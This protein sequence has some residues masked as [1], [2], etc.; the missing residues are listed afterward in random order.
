MEF[1]FKPIGVLHTPNIEKEKSPIQS[2]RS[3]LAGT[4]EVFEEY[5][6]GL[7][8]I[9]DFSHIYLFYGFHKA[10]RDVRLMVQPFLDDQ[11]RGLFATRYP[12]RPNPLGISIVRVTGREGGNLHFTGA[13]ML[14]G[15]PLF[16]IKPYIPEFDHF[17]VEKMGWYSNRKK[18]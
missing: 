11:L 10:S 6:Q 16:D 5:Q 7:T 14:D 12:V 3:E 15:T 18:R 8:G 17:V 9:E 2:A 1:N 4:A 13:D